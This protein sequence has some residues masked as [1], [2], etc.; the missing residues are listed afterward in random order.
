MF[1]HVSSQ[2]AFL[3]IGVLRIRCVGAWIHASYGMMRP[4]KFF[5]SLEEVS[6]YLCQCACILLHIMH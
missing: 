3:G 5:P 6:E 2:K 4:L 1:G